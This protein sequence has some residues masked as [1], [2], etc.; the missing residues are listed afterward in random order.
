MQE[1]VETAGEFVV[2][3]GDS[4]KLLEPIEEAFNQMACC[5][6]P[7]ICSSENRFFKSIL[8]L[9]NGLY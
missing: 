1:S 4:T 9:E 3:R 6:N 8:L 5:K 2:A 7:M